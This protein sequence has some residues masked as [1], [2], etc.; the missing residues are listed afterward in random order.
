MLNIKIPVGAKAAIVYTIA[1]V[2]S[3]G[4]AIITMPIFTRVM[5]TSEIGVVSLYNAW[6]AMISC[7]STLSLTSGGF[8]VGLT[9]FHEK[10]KEYISSIL[11]LTS[12]L[13]CLI[14]IIYFLR[15][16]FW[17]K[18]TGLSPQ[19]MH[20][21]IFS[22]LVTPATELWL[23]HQ[24]YEY[25]YKASA[26]L[27]GISALLASLS[28]LA[29][30][31]IM[32]QKGMKNLSE[33]RLY[34]QEF[35]VLGV[36]S[37]LWCCLM[38]RGRTFINIQYWKF[39]LSLSLPLVG[40]AIASQILGVSDRVM[41]GTMVGDGA[42]G[43]YSTV[44]S[45][46]SL[47]TMVWTAINASFVPYLYQNIGKDN[48]SIRKISFNIL[49][50]YSLV[51]VVCVFMAPE[52]VRILATKEYYEAIYI[53]PPIAIGV[54]MTSI[55]NM[56]SNIL[57]Y[58]KKSK[59][60]MY[61]SAIAAALNVIL[62]LVCIPAWGYMAAAYTTMFSYIAMLAILMIFTIKNFKV[63]KQ[64]NLSDVYGNKKIVVLATILA[65]VLLFG[66]LLYKY[67]IIRYI[68][69]ALILLYLSVYI[70]RIV[71]NSDG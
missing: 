54:F 15:P 39:S 56:Y 10:R 49:L 37:V 42:V 11:T 22:L 6:F 14:A 18:I 51:S 16:S 29:I 26:L 4:L 30:V 50:G 44:Y 20:M 8:S 17:N 32:N 31:L 46:S 1:N 23:A 3:R 63:Q 34:G 52:V 45:V 70:L 59:Y 21:L 2:L 71:R 61:A 24:R 48:K 9:E 38:V 33:G 57:L 41:I 68:L 65:L 25:K 36:A 12:L 13:S 40:Y 69:V 19:L 60:I 43:I 27:V 67:Y 28:S 35:I 53:M 66:I 7:L 5:P 47:F 55:S 58:L 62:N 64:Q